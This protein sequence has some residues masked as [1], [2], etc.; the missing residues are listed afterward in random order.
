MKTFKTFEEISENFPLNSKA[1]LKFLV[2]QCYSYVSAQKDLELLKKEYPFGYYNK[3]EHKWYFWNIDATVWYD[4]YI[5][6]GE[7][8]ILGIDDWDGINYA[9]EPKWG[10]Q[11][12]YTFPKSNFGIFRTIEEAEEYRN[13]KMK[14]LFEF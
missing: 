11:Y 14:E 5:Y 2:R 3:E 1:N 10:V 4:C 12:T 9:E 8:W 7:E 13:K 6:N